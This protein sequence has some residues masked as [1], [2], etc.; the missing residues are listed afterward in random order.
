M[1]AKC[2]QTCLVIVEPGHSF[3]KSWQ[4]DPSFYIQVIIWSI[5]DFSLFPRILLQNATTEQIPKLF[6]FQ[7]F[8]I[9]CVL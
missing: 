6:W 7:S 8:S 4:T 1:L 2:Y 5:N 3:H 9:I